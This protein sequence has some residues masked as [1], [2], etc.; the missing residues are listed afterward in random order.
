MFKDE[1]V[2]AQTSM[3]EAEKA[4]IHRLKK[5]AITDRAP[6]NWSTLKASVR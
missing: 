6:K 5:N 3:Q 2:M 1:Q 4:C